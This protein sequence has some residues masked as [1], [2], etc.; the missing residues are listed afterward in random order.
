MSLFGW[1]PNADVN[2]I[3]DRE[4]SNNDLNATR[5]GFADRTGAWN[6][7]DS[8]GAWMA[9]TNK[10]EVLRLASE[11]ANQNLTT[12][13]SP[14]AGE[15]SALLGPL[16]SRYKGVAGKTKEQLEAE[17][18]SDERRGTALQTAIAQNPNLNVDSLSPTATAGQIY[19]A[20][21]Q[22]T[23]D[24]QER[25]SNDVGGAKYTARQ[26]QQRYDEGVRRDELIRS[27]GRLD[28]NLQRQQTAENNK[29]Q[30]QLEYARLAQSDRQRTADRKDK[31]IMA[32]LSG[33]GNLGAGFTI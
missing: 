16:N 20:S 33:L 19:Q 3:V 2:S 28:R 17:I 22:A 27:E 24:E 14:R 32:L 11:K 18:T 25:A 21:A 23:R 7:Q 1:L 12:S 10:E 29:M 8:V 9:G 15:A 31:A 26:N 6:W 13:L 5:D 30:L 4:L